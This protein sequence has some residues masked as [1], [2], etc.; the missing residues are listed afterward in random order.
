M[1]KEQTASVKIKES[2]LESAKEESKINT[3]IN[4]AIHNGRYI[5]MSSEL[6]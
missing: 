2:E 5:L 3:E 1:E 6:E 4:H